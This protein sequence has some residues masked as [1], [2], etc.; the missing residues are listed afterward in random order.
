MEGNKSNIL[1]GKNVSLD[2][3]DKRILEVLQKEA[4]LPISKIAKKLRL[5]PDT[6]KY[7]IRR[8]ENLGVI[9]FYHA[10]LNFPLLGNP[11]YSYTLLA[12]YA[13]DRKKESEFIE[14]LRQQ[15][16]ITWISKTSGKWDFIIGTCT[17]DFKEFDELL[18]EMRV[19]FVDYIKDYETVSTIDEYKWDMMY[20]VI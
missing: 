17:K 15:P 13:M 9:R 12:L 1:F 19:R 18:H 3:K 5:P 8:M 4:R 10:V 14:Y 11:M 2:E 6:V 16:K 7:R 20:D